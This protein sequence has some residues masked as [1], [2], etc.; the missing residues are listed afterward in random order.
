MSVARAWGALCL[1]LVFGCGRSSLD[2][3]ADAPA[4]SWHYQI[5]VDQA[6]TRIDAKVCF[7]GVVPRELRAGR[8]EA[9]GRLLYARWLGPGPVRRLPVDAGRIQ[10]DSS[11]RDGCVGYGIR[12]SEGGSMEAAVRRVGSDLLASP[13]VW[14]WR[15]ERRAPELSA[16]IELELPARM[17]ALLPWPHRGTRYQLDAEAF[18]FDSYAAF[19]RLT[20]WAA[21]EHGVAIETVL[22]DG[23]L[24]IDGA[25]ALR[26]LRSAV[27]LAALSDGA[28]P[29]DR[30]SA[31]LVPSGARAEPV[32]F[33]MVAR[34]GAAS[35]L[36]LLSESAE[37]PALLRD[38]VLPHE[39]SHLLLPFVDRE[40]AWLSEGLATYYQEL[41]L[42]RAGARSERD[43]LCELAEA[44]RSAATEPSR[45]GLH[46]AQP[47][48]QPG[49]ARSL[50]EESARM[51][52]S[53]SYRKVYWGGAAFWFGA[54]VELRRR[55][56]GHASVDTLL[57]QLRREDMPRD[58]WTAD[59]L[60]GRLDALAGMHVFSEAQALAA[61]T[62][63]PPFEPTLAA[64]GV[65]GSGAELELDDAAP[66][67]ELRHQLF[68][69]THET[70]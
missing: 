56:Q 12:L 9:A 11:K 68:A 17:Q 47:E 21:Q 32:A 15:P 50:I 36:L 27:H 64:L 28:F 51:R 54:D 40:Q 22:L 70:R 8:D 67:A 1:A 43:A 16:S 14:L 46:G 24:A 30:L 38:W 48:A 66:L 39:L 23:P 26:W 19:G 59:A 31:I 65:R 7:D 52:A 45:D 42:A 61:S 53:H 6:L 58:V 60:L 4:T 34:G 2:R 20:V 35:V 49:E 29:R 57:S 33:G 13:N 55:T 3:N 25:A 41:L 44:F 62:P 18:R 37:E 69:L 63:F 10:L 5:A